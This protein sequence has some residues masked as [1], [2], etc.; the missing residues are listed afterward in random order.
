MSLPKAET[1]F[2][3]FW[4]IAVIALLANVVLAFFR[5]ALRPAVGWETIAKICWHAALGLL[6]FNVC[7][8]FGKVVLASYQPARMPRVI[9]PFQVSGGSEDAARRGATLA[10]LLS[11]RLAEIGKQI[12]ASEQSLEEAQTAK[13]QVVASEGREASIRPIDLPTD[14]FRPLDLTMSVANVELGKLVG[15]VYGWLAEDNAL[16]LSVVYTGDKAVATGHLTGQSDE[17]I[18]VEGPGNDDLQLISDL[19]YAIAQ[20][21]YAVRYP[22]LE[23]LKPRDFGALLGSLHRVANLSRKAPRIGVT[24]DEYGAE[25]K[26]LEPLLRL[27]LPKWR[28][29]LRLVA[30]LAER[31][32]QTDE[33]IALY[34]QL[35]AL[36]DLPAEAE[37]RDATTKKIDTL[38]SKLLAA[39]A[40]PIAVS[41]TGTEPTAKKV[42]AALH[43]PPAPPPHLGRPL[44][45]IAGAAPA[46]GILPDG[47]QSKLLKT[48]KAEKGQPDQFLIEHVGRLVSSIQMVFPEVDFVFVQMDSRDGA[49]SLREISEAL[50]VMLKSDPVPDIIL[51]P[52][53]GGTGNDPLPQILIENILARDILLV[54]AAGNN[55]ESAK[56]PLPPFPKG[57]PLGPGQPLRKQIAVAAAASFDGKPAPFTQRDVEV[58][59][60]PGLEIDGQSGTSFS[61]ALTAGA[62][63]WIKAIHPDVKPADIVAALQ[64]TSNA[65]ADPAIKIIDV[66]AA[67]EKL[68]PVKNP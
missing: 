41:N 48:P 38:H 30:D 33:A 16:S 39:S 60:A 6:L 55:S 31:S 1:L 34:K 62:V 64:E 17:M 56:S 63:A 42:R 61:A 9:K 66:Q 68:A 2:R 45:G 47:A 32:D 25:Y 51:H 8:Y 3:A 13:P 57:S 19:A 27:H 50:A 54:L 10:A 35:L 67:L 36:Y 59:W 4:I 5:P 26:V 14:V 40:P 11:G 46:P 53:S 20:K 28:P 18:W 21:P 29:L 15:W 43:I 49:M 52:Y 24:A 65:N 44:I 12:R 22:E 37:D 58:L 7:L 23:Y